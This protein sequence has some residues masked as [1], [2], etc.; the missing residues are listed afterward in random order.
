[1]THQLRYPA[2]VME[3]LVCRSRI[4][5][6]APSP[7]LCPV[8]YADP[9]AALTEIHEL[10]DTLNDHFTAIMKPIYDDRLTKVLVAAADLALPGL[11]HVKTEQHKAFLKRI[12]LT[13]ANGDEFASIVCAWWNA[14]QSSVDEMTLSVQVAWMPLNEKARNE[15]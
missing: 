10:V 8:H 9:S 7:Q 13:V 11:H 6:S 12:E 2:N 1:M 4:K 5:P 15:R 14:R 3:C